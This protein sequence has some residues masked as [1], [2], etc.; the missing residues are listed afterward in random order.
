MEAKNSLLFD[1]KAP[2]DLFPAQLN[3]VHTFRFLLLHICGES[4]SLHVLRYSCNKTDVI[5]VTTMYK[6]CIK[7]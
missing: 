2:L 1:N 5:I 7:A 6:K 3:S 4:E